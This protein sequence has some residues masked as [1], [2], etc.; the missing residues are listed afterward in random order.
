MDETLEALVRREDE[1]RWLSSRFA[2][3]PA[4]KRLMALYAFNIE[5]S[6]TAQRA[7][8]PLT[9]EMR[10]QFWRDALEAIYAGQTAPASP[11][12]AAL[13][14][15][16]AEAHLPHARFA[17]IIEARR[18]DLE[19][20]PF[21]S[22]ADLEAY[23]DATSGALMLLAAQACAPVKPP[24][25]RQIVAVR[26]AGRAWGYAGLVRALPFW[27]AQRRTFFPKKLREHVGVN[28]ASLFSA[29]PGDH[30][31]AAAA[32]AVLNRAS[33]AYQDLRRH[34]LWLTKDMFPA[35]GHISLVPQYV[36][37]VAKAPD[38]LRQNVKT[39]LIGRQLRLVGAAATGS[40]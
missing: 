8:D 19:A 7:S 1:D 25:D 27:S 2:D 17:A 38:T 32:R 26:A 12:V 6:A 11:I 36:R 5:L 31:G 35:I 16:I 9:G 39:S 23:V 21:D 13:S 3:A 29:G 34:A 15:A 14:E 22:W 10:L 18:H 20:A 24:S 30:A 33:G 37:A 40:L 28:E 4:R